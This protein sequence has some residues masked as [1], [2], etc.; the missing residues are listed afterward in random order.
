MQER[1]TPLMTNE[2]SV[3]GDEEEVVEEEEEELV[4]SSDPTRQSSTSRC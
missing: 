2:N 4:P 3:N 1:N